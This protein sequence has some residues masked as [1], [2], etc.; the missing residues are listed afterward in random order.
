[1]S[2][3]NFIGSSLSIRY[4]FD[5]PRHK[6]LD[7]PGAIHH[8]IVRGLN[9]QDIFLDDNDRGDFIVR[10][11]TGLSQTGCRCYAR[12]LLSNRFQT[13]VEWDLHFGGQYPLSLLGKVDA[14]QKLLRL[15]HGLY[16]PDRQCGSSLR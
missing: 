16:V 5:M 12:A 4:D 9:R 11:G 14:L 3:I 13:N 10:L 1:M 7:I 2:L 6:R 15:T 8:V